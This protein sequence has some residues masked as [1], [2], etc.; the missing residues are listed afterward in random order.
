VSL[1]GK[2]KTIMNNLVK[3]VKQEQADRAE[4]IEKLRIRKMLILIEGKDKAITNLQREKQGLK[5][6]LEAGDYSI[7]TLPR[8]LGY[9]PGYINGSTTFTVPTAQWTITKTRG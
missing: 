5:D 2:N 1:I 6:M 4:E 9:N 7:L 8:N 3:Q